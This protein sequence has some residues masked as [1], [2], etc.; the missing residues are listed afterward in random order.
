MPVSKIR[1]RTCQGCG[2]NYMLGVDS[3]QHKYCSVKCRKSWHAK[4]FKT[5]E[6]TKRD[7]RKQKS[8]W[9]RNK[10]GIDI[11]DYERMLKDQNNSCAICKTTVPTG[12]NWHVDHCHET[13]SVRSLLCSRCNQ[14]IGLVDES[15]EILESMKRY[16]IEHS[17]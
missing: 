15:L 14:A 8:Y 5:S 9:L 12:Y 11:S 2:K 4:K 13:G 1:S 16:L 17:S 6:R 7:P 10:Y 3:S